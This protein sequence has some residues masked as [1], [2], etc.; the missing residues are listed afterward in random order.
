MGPALG[1]IRNVLFSVIGLW[2]AWQDVGEDRADHEIDLVALQQT[3][4]LRDGGVRLQL[5]IDDD[6]LDIPAGHLA[7]EILDRERKTVADLLASAAAGPDSVTI[8]PTLIFSCARRGSPRRRQQDRNPAN[9]N[10]CIMTTPSLG[11]PHA[12]RVLL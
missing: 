6:D 12:T 11:P 10:G 4:D 8:T 9:F 1:L 7:A 2:M 5:V 3:L